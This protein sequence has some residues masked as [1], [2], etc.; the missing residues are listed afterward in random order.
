MYL[1]GFGITYHTKIDLTWAWA[2]RLVMAPSVQFNEIAKKLAT[3]FCWFFLLLHEDT[4][5]DKRWLT[6]YQQI[7][8]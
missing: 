6:S 1:N 7:S 3:D 4:I 5:L 2:V 8:Q